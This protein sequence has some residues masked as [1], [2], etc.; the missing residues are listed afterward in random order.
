M[1][2][3]TRMLM[4]M[5]N[6]IER[7]LISMED[8]GTETALAVIN[9][10]VFVML[11]QICFCAL[12]VYYKTLKYD[13]IQCEFTEVYVRI[14]KDDLPGIEPMRTNIRRSKVYPHIIITILTFGLYSMAMILY[15]V[16]T[17]NQ[18]IRNQWNYEENL[19]SMIYKKEQANGIIRSDAG[20]GKGIM[21]TIMHFM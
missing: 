5:L 12:Y 15:A 2:L 16:N 11:L 10:L 18:H 19:L 14:M 7:Q 13:T 20:F 4:V 21:A 1:E 6:S 8:M 3:I 17:L 9:F